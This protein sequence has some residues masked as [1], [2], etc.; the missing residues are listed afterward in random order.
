MTCMEALEIIEHEAKFL[1][2][3]PGDAEKARRL[4]FQRHRQAKIFLWN[5]LNEQGSLDRESEELGLWYG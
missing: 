1:L 2:E 4:S 3:C 5:Y